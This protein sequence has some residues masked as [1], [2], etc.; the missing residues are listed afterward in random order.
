MSTGAKTLARSTA[1][2]VGGDADRTQL[3]VLACESE[4]VEPGS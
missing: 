4:L 2:G 1:G 3:V